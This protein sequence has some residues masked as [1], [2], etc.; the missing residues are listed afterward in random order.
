MKFK[1]G[2]HNG[3][4]YGDH[5]IIKELPEEFKKQFPWLGGNT[6]KYITFTV[7]IEKKRLEGLIKMEK[8][9]QKKI[10]YILQ[11]IDSARFTTRSLSNLVNNLSEGIHKIKCKYGHD[12]KKC[13]TCGIKYKYCRWFNRNRWFKDD[14]IEYK[15]LYCNKKEQQKFDKQLKER[16]LNTCKHPIHDN[17]KFILL[18]WKS[19]YPN[20]YMDDLEKFNKTSLPEKEK[21][22][23]VT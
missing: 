22:F 12:D 1:I 7:P 20:K 15:C 9:I 23:T 5:F 2:F 8:K 13:E 4:N 19:L 16:F 10:S 14:L 6:E 17:N 11:F 21:I 18:L 3:S